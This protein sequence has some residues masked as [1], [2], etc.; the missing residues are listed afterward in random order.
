MDFMKL[1]SRTFVDI[2]P[3]YAT[4]GALEEGMDTH[5]RVVENGSSSNILVVSVPL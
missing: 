5:Q 4:M 3:T 1:N 2:L